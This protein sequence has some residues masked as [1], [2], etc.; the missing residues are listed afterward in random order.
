MSEN[1][2]VVKF[3]AIDFNLEGDILMSVRRC[4]PDMTAI[5]IGLLLLSPIQIF[6]PIIQYKS[7]SSEKRKD[8]QEG[9]FYCRK[10]SAI[11]CLS[12]FPSPHFEA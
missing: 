2:T 6:N 12:E 11:P 7:D 4:T 5:T 1:V 8:L 3:T 10:F 9:L